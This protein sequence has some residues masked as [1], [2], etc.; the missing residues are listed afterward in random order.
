MP[1]DA[2]EGKGPQRRPQTRLDRRLPKR[3][4][5]LLSVTNAIEAGTCCHGAS[6][7]AWVRRPRGGLPPLPMHRCWYPPPPGP[8]FHYWK[9]EVYNRKY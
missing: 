2:L 6:G 4:G 7:W 5:A 9:N 1:R 8:R 3:L